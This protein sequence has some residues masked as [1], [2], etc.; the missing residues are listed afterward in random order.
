MKRALTMH[1]SDESIFKDT[2]SIKLFP[3]NKDTSASVERATSF[4]KLNENSS[5]DAEFM[6]GE[7]DKSSSLSLLLPPPINV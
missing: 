1:S 3:S 4:E 2:V 5:N 6:P 7:N